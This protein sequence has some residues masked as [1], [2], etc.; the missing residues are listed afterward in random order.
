MTRSFADPRDTFRHET[1]AARLIETAEAAVAAS[2]VLLEESHR[3]SLQSAAISW[4]HADLTYE[5]AALRKRSQVS[6]RVA[7]I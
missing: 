5:W 3:L 4:D 6:E 2:A 7:R 1:V